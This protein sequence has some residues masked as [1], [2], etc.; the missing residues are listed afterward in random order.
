MKFAPD[1]RERVK[2]LASKGLSQEKIAWVL[3]IGETTLK[4]NFGAD[5]AGI[6]PSGARTL[7]ITPEQRA[8][9]EA[10]VGMGATQEQVAAVMGIG[11]NA[12]KK[13][14]SV[15]LERGGTKAT[16]AVAQSLFKIATGSTPQAVTAAIFWMKTRAKWHEV[17]RIIHGFD[18]ETVMAFVRQ[19]VALLRKELPEACPHCKTRLD[20][21][22]RVAGELRK[23]SE[24]LAEGMKPSEIVPIPPS[25]QNT[26]QENV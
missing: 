1:M 13:Y 18:P 12:L 6:N 24:K 19:V 16:L 15:E 14:C 10:A 4:K 26:V 21:P 7:E 23:L 22:Q 20:L 11:V 9:V 5:L 17:Q 3:G 25:D 2:L 8:Q